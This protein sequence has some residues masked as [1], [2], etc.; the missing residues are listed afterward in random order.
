MNRYKLA[1]FIALL[2]LVLIFGGC[3]PQGASSSTKG[4]N[5]SEGF[6]SAEPNNHVTIGSQSPVKE[7]PAFSLKKLELPSHSLTAV[8]PQQDQGLR[9]IYGAETTTNVPVIISWSKDGRVIA[10]WPKNPG[11]HHLLMTAAISSDVTAFSAA[12]AFVAGVD[13]EGIFVRSINGR[14]SPIKLSRL[15]TRIT[16][17]EFSP[18]GD[19]LLIG[20]VDGMVYL[21]NFRDE[22]MQN[23]SS[24]PEWYLHR[25]PGL[26]SAVSALKFHPN[27]RLFF[28]SDLRGAVSAWQ[29]YELDGPDGYPKNI[30][31]QRFLTA[32]TS[33]SVIRPG[34]GKGVDRI[35]L[36]SKA[37]YL[38]LG[39]QNGTIEIWKLRGIQKQGVVQAHDGQII[40]LEFN[41][42]SKNN[43]ELVSV[44][45]DGWIR[46]WE[47]ITQTVTA[48]KGKKN[49]N[50]ED[51]VARVVAKLVPQKVNEISLSNVITASF[52]PGQG[53]FVGSKSGDIS[54]V[55]ILKNQ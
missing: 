22:M 11:N 38:A 27:G 9:V 43:L 12:G 37:Q 2:S 28:A 40:S 54:K 34:D 13:P 32:Q 44:G 39:V 5:F 46:S 17:L 3:A 6:Q 33:R 25:Y 21:W 16:A 14:V 35:V 7:S 10:N 50:S 48:A 4:P 52:V 30:T 19:S 53:Y 23:Q 24:R 18:E 55:Q 41:P 42:S 15:M 26:G 45:K 49:K 8:K 29:K 47:S 51:G 31:G 20:G 1:V 36:D